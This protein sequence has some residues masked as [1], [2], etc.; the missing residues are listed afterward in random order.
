MYEGRPSGRCMALVPCWT[1]RSVLPSAPVIGVTDQV[2]DLKLLIR[3]AMHMAATG[4]VDVRPASISN[5]VRSD[6][7]RT[8][9]F[10]PVTMSKARGAEPCCK[11]ALI[12]LPGE[13]GRV[14]PRP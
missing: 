13:N 10:R 3:C 5:E 4:Q 6:R 12:G 11:Y 1:A 7:G 8:L 14:E 9:M 2:N